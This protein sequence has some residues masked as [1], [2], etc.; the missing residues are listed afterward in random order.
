MN[1]TFLLAQAAGGSPVNMIIMFAAMIGIFYFM[2]MRPQQKRVKEHQALLG[3]VK[4]GDKVI[5]N[6]GMHGTIHEVEDKT[7]LV[8][9]ARNT[10]VKFDKA[11]IQSVVAA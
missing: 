4:R 5:L 3:S 8:E 2:V 10:V 9:I 7:V 1:F 6:N 11:A